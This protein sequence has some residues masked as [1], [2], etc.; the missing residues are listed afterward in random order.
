MMAWEW[1]KE[2]RSGLARFVTNNVANLVRIPENRQ[3]LVRHINGRHRLV[4]A[5]YNA[6]V[7]LDKQ[8]RYA[9]EKYHPLDF[10]QQIR[11]P[12]EILD[13]PGEGTCLDLALLFCGLCMA[14]EL[15]PLLIVLEGHALVAVSL[16]H[17]LREWD[18]QYRWEE[19]EKILL[20]EPLTNADWLRELID[21]GRYIAIECTGFAYSKSLSQ[22]FPEGEGRTEE[23][24]LEFERAVNAGREQLNRKER[25]LQF[26]FDIAIAH[27]KWRYTPVAMGSGAVAIDGFIIFQI[28][29]KAPRLLSQYIR[30]E[31]FKSLVDDKTRNF[32]GR[33]FIFQSIN[34]LLANPEFS[35][36]Y[37]VISGEPGIGKSSVLAQFIKNR[38][39]VHH[40][41]SVLMGIRS[42][43][44]FL[45]NICAQLIVRYQLNYSSL[46]PEATKDSGF[47]SQLLAEIANQEQHKPV[48]IL[49][50]ALDEAEDTGLP[51]RA[52]RLFLPPNLPAGVFF[53]V[54]SREEYD[55][56]LN[57][58]HRK[59]IYLRDNDPRNL[60]DVR[61]YIR[62]YLQEHRTKISPQIETWGVS[63][64]EFINVITEK[65]EGNFMYLVFVL[66]D[67]RDGN[68]TKSNVDN[69][70]DLP[71]G[72]KGYYKQHWRQ[73]ENADKQNFETYYKPVACHLAVAKEPVSINKL[74]EWTKLDTFGITKV[75]HT[76]HQFFNNELNSRNNEYL[77]RIYHT[78][79]QTF[80]REDV[81]LKLYEK[82]VVASIKSKIRKKK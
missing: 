22:D 27:Y 71:Q 74:V 80:L 17:G 70:H 3:D 25:P 9:P 58:A 34:D 37:I 53:I 78:T 65:S 64:E 68:L 26:V 43:Q 4:Q 29:T 55:Y 42:H 52:N 11:T 15:L 1:S 18:N 24:I 28:F 47:L 50:D 75:I 2:D 67:I 16:N 36:G 39:A 66:G 56:R 77:Y 31:Q 38:G 59:D 19:K 72:L 8:I 21:S 40:F 62:N 61:Q 30:V 10:Q 35:S 45:S 23:G 13:T 12:E 73:M 33:E 5:I 76:W 49:V 82:N 54:T 6:L 69:I 20:Y 51:D 79:F 60:E 7:N 81:G 63:E 41:N 32:V 46:P 14:N 57:V 48:V 44:V